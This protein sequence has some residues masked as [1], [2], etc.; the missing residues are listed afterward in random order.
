MQ[1]P[2]RPKPHPNVRSA[3]ITAMAAWTI[4][5]AAPVV[6]AKLSP[7]HL[8][9]GAE[10]PAGTS[11]CAA[12]AAFIREIWP[13]IASSGDVVV[14]ASLP[15]PYDMSG[16]DHQP[17]H[18]RRVT[19]ASPIWQGG[20]TRRERPSAAL[21][22]DWLAKQDGDA[23]SCLRGSGAPARVIDAQEQQRIV[24]DWHSGTRRRALSLGQPVWDRGGS[25]ALMHV[26]TAGAGLS[27]EDFLILL[28][29]VHGRWLELSRLLLAQS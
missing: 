5:A 27:G 20:W 8:D 15:P 1:P 21:V 23:S 18:L 7:R 6:A 28:G 4:P 26:S 25:R 29:K 2:R 17:D 13:L 16:S 22:R 14:D 12:T 19:A 11:N 10:S 3:I 24:Q 9:G